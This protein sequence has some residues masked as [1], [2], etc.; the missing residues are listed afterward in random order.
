ME[1]EDMDEHV[2]NRLLEDMFLKGQFIKSVS[3]PFSREDM[4]KLS[5]SSS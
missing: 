5:T 1:T 2:G 3:D 4:S